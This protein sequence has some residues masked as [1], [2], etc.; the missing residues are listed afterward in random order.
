MAKQ[1]N[2]APSKKKKEDDEFYDYDAARKAG[3]TG[4]D[5]SGHWPSDFKKE[6]HPN[7]V[8]GGFNTKTGE[9]VPGTKHGTKKELL[10]SGWDEESAERLGRKDDM[11]KKFGPTDFKPKDFNK[12]TLG[13][14]AINK[15]S[16]TIE[17]ASEETRKKLLARRK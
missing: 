9:R 14:V 2:T 15:K 3:V 4:P 6:G 8:V 7:L 16:G 1:I 17:T 12:K 10:D 13:E 11:A 5:A